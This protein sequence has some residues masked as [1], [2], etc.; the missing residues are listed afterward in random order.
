M[1]M[2]F[3]DE[4]RQSLRDPEAVQQEQN[5]RLNAA[6]KKEA[7][8]TL[9]RLRRE[10]VA[11]AKSAHYTTTGAD[12]TVC[13]ICAIPQRFIRK[14]RM[15]NNAQLI[16]NNKR[17][18]FRDRSIVYRVWYSFELDTHYEAEYRQFT[19]I[20]RQLANADGISVD[21]L[22]YDTKTNNCYPFPTRLDGFQI[23]S[24]FVLAVKG[25]S[26]VSQ[27]NSP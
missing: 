17:G 19:S 3:Q 6:L 15:D 23:D 24:Y 25:V 1:H 16:A 10:M 7:S 22:L 4:L 26:Q 27:I 12:A 20:F 18:I 14:R 5:D 21:F 9:A 13:A 2:N 11:N 8:Q